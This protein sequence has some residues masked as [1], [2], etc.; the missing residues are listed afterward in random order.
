MLL[1]ENAL[2]ATMRGGLASALNLTPEQLR[3]DRSFLAQGGDSLSAIQFMA[4]CLAQGVQANIADI[5]KH[6]TLPQLLSE[7][8]VRMS[9]S[10][11]PTQSRRTASVG[12]VDSIGPCSLMQNRILIGQA[13]HPAAYHCSFILTAR[14]RDRSLLSANDVAKH[15]RSVVDRHPSLRTTFIESTER[16]GTFDQVVWDQ[17]QPSVTILQ[18]ESQI[19]Q[20][21]AVHN[22]TAK[23]G[24][25]MYL[26]QMTPSQVMLRLNI[27]HAIIDG[28]SAGIVLRDFCDAFSGKMTPGQTLRHADFAIAEDQLVDDTTEDFWRTY[29][30]GVEETYLAGNNVTNKAKTGLHTLQGK[31]HIS[32][33]KTRKFCHDHGI[34]VVNVCQVAWGMVLRAFALRDDISYSYI[35]SARQTRLPGMSEAVGLFISSLVLRM[36]FATNTKVLDLLKA[37]NGDVLRHMPHDRG[38]RKRS[39]KWGNSILSFQRAWQT[40]ANENDSLQF[41]VLRRL[42]PTDYDH[43]LNVEIGDD[44]IVVDYDI[45]KSTTDVDYANNILSAYLRAIEFVLTSPE[46]DFSEGDLLGLEDSKRLQQ[47]NRIPPTSNSTCIHAIV[48]EVTSRQPDAMAVCAWDGTMTFR[49]L[50]R[51]AGALANHGEKTSRTFGSLLISLPWLFAPA[52]GSK[53]F[54]AQSA[55]YDC[56]INVFQNGMYYK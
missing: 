10:S 49:Q 22:N 19:D 11:L 3:L 29:L 48:A 28:R 23:I 5:L 25:H 2:H 24:H 9:T 56:T 37:A 15:W 40:E 1:D 30:H 8:V 31:L 46:A 17:V 7:L 36:D 20:A 35:T 33:E 27:S 47:V 21:Q 4:R 51:A 45:W 50:D 53:D 55:K 41:E 38:L 34:T 6:D 43:S 18:D 44:T 32:A 16:S 52:D 14:T 42:S 12:H 13:V 26:V 54:T 39:S